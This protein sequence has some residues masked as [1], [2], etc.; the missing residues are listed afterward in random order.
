M[1]GAVYRRILLKL[2]G[3][4]L[5]G[6]DQQGLNAERIDDL[7]DSLKKVKELGV[8][9]SVVVGGGNIFRGFPASAR[10]VDRETADYMGMLATVINGLALEEALTRAGV[11]ACALSALDMGE[12]I[13]TYNP[14]RARR[15]L[16]D[17][18]VVILSGGTG[19]PFFSTDTAAA[20]RAAELGADALLKA[21]KVDGV[22]AA[23]PRQHPEAQHF[24]CITYEEFINRG[25]RVMDTTSVVLCMENKIPIVVFNMTKKG[26][27]QRVLMGE[28]VGSLVKEAC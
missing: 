6:T 17:G 26:N 11:G 23:D 19:K 15:Y 5:S 21:T 10:G 18:K 4:T 3:E 8:E 1:A 28:A 14:R 13:Q 9:L 24:P 20:L 7:A 16:Q 2:S 22:F 12:V 27:L 25:L